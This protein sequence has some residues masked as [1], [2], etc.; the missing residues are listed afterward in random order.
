M[1]FWGTGAYLEM[2]LVHSCASLT[3]C[4]F[5][6]SRRKNFQKLPLE[7]LSLCI[8]REMSTFA[9][10]MVCDDIPVTLRKLLIYLETREQDDRQDNTWNT[11]ILLW[12]FLICSKAQ[13][14]RKLTSAS[15]QLHLLSWAE[16]ESWY[17]SCVSCC[18]Q[19]SIFCIY[20]IGGDTAHG[21]VFQDGREIFHGY[22]LILVPISRTVKVSYLQWGYW[23][24][25]GMCMRT[26]LW[27]G[28]LRCAEVWSWKKKIILPEL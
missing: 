4:A 2:P 23:Q 22:C 11:W 9:E 24:L 25:Q 10:L 20:N 13:F 5:Y 14:R 15:L 18:L 17:G 8:L 28:F 6:T 19:G 7:Y 12:H 1:L 27:T 3:L 16:G 26:I 21:C